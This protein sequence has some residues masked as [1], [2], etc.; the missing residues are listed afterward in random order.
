MRDDHIF[1]MAPPRSGTE[2]LSRSLGRLPETYLITEHK[3][4]EEIPEEKNPTPDRE[5]WQE[6]FGLSRLPEEVSEEVE[7][8]ARAFARLN[9]LWTANSGDRRLIIKN[10]NNVVRARQ[11]RRALPNAKFVWLL[12][13]PWSVIQSM[14]GGKRAGQKRGAFVAASEVLQ[15]KDPV[16]RAAAG[17]FFSVQVMR[18]IALPTDIISWYENIVAQPEQ[19]LKRIVALAGLA[20]TEGAAA[21]PHVRKDDFAPLRYLLRRS[22]VREQILE[23][24]GPVASELGYPG[25]PPQGFPGDDWIFGIRHFL[26]CI[27]Q[28]HKERPYGFPRAQKISAAIIDA[29][30]RLSR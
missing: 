15:H 23:L 1:I 7:F 16:L 25:T 18:N 21:V 22:P 20:F 17:W 28:P 19:E 8:D 12:R 6:T 30:P 29:R 26:Y 2:M 11:I 27:R 9:Q 13:N 3:N 10:P 4:K 24:I 14:L 5:F